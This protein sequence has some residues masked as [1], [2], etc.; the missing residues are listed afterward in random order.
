MRKLFATLPIQLAMLACIAAGTAISTASRA[1]DIDIY[2]G[3]PPAAARPNVLIILDSS[4]NWSASISES[5]CTYND[6]SGSPKATNPGKEQGTKMAIEKCALYN[7]IDSLPTDKY[8]IGLMLFNESPAANSGGYPRKAIITLDSAGKTALKTVIRNLAIGGD[9]GNNAAFSK[10]LYEAYLYLTSSAPYKGTAGSKWDSAAVSGGKYVLPSGSNCTNH[11]IFIANGGPGEVTDNE[12]KALLGA[13]GGDTTQISYPT[14]IVTNSDQ[15]NW[16]D[17]FT[18]F[19]RTKAIVTHAIAVTGASSDGKYPNFIQNIAAKGGG[20]YASASNSIDLVNALKDVFDKIQSV[21]S[22]FASPSLP[23][24]VNQQ[25]TYINQVFMGM[26]LPDADAYPRWFGNLKQYHFI[27]D[28][29]TYTLTLADSTDAPAIN[30]TG[31]FIQTKAISY[32]TTSSDFWVN[33]PS[34]DPASSSDSPDGAIV[35][36]GGAAEVLRKDNLTDQTSR[37]VF[38]CVSCANNTALG[39]A[40]ATLFDTTN[41]AITNS[42]LGVST[43]SDAQ[44]L[45]NWVR[46]IDNAGDELGPGGTTTV[47]PS[48]HGDVVH[49]KPAVVNYGGSTGVVVFYGAND[50]MLHAVHGDQTGT[51]AGHHLWSFVP[52]EMFSKFKRMRDNS[53]LISF[54]NLI[55]SDPTAARDWFVDGPISVYQKISSSGTIEKAYLYVGMRR[56]GRLLYAFDITNPTNPRFL[57]KK[58]SSDISILGQTWSEARVMKIKGHTNPVIVMGAGYDAAAEDASTPGTVT[59]G[60]AVLVLDAFSGTLVHTFSGIERPVPADVTVIDSDYDGYIDRA[61]AVDLGGNIYRIDFETSTSAA[62][63]VW[64]IH[65]LAELGSSGG[66]KFFYAPDVVLTKKY[67]VILAGSGDREKPLSATTQDYFYT[68]LDYQLGKALGDSFTPIKFSDLVSQASYVASDSAKGC[69][70]QFD[71]GQKVVN[72]PA[73]IG[74]VTYFSTNKPKAPDA[75][76]CSANLGEAKQ[77]S[78]PLV[79]KTPTSTVLEGGGLPPSPVTGIVEVTY[80]NPATGETETKDVPF[81][82]GGENPYNSSIGVERVTLPITPKRSKVYWYTESER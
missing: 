56:G 59:M 27:Y 77:Y 4:A 69:Y 40:A 3:A 78:F 64:A 65:K 34:G 70:L 7:L 46:G 30:N 17:E 48:I 19:M 20:V 49:S 18:R 50:G 1:E 73:T 57:W 80:T 32:W 35:A 71:V 31:G 6:G 47:R 33:A 13:A 25:G 15:S 21:S 81:I 79:C 28:P 61:Y 39:G 42:M 75:N 74:G 41:T 62:E 45:I 11:V 12:A 29:V 23:V 22:V 76:S 44:T 54:P 10:S 72:K 9:K 63:S 66:K 36:K 67:A 5:N 43:A 68:V 8:N 24:S 55:T 2:A 51:N 60:N 37:K 14:S 52:E 82:I 16:A 58:S 26:F 38:T 53:P